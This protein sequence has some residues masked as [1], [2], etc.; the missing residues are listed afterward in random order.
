LAPL[1]L[2]AYRESVELEAIV[3]AGE[4]QAVIAAAAQRELR[5]VYAVVSAASTPEQ[6]RQLLAQREQLEKQYNTAS[7]LA[8]AAIRAAGGLCHLRNWMPE[9]FGLE[10]WT[11]ERDELGRIKS[12]SG[13]LTV[14]ICPTKT[15]E[16]AST[17][18]INPYSPDSWKN[19]PRAEPAPRR[20]FRT[21]QISPPAGTSA[22]G[23]SPQTRF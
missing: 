13:R 5:T 2:T 12:G 9:L 14:T 23:V 10:N 19:L 8:E 1:L 6:A 18:S 7:Q 11:R 20:R 21:Q 15:M 17:L 16:A 4:G 22:L 3:A